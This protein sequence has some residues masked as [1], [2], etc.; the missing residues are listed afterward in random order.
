VSTEPIRP[1]ELAKPV[2][3]HYFTR[4]WYIDRWLDKR[5]KEAGHKMLAME[6]GRVRMQGERTGQSTLY[7]ATHASVAEFYS[8][9][10][11]P[12]TEAVCRSF[13]PQA[14]LDKIT[15]VNANGVK[16]LQGKQAQDLR[17]DF[18][19]LDAAN[20]AEQGRRLLVACARIAAP[21]CIVLMDDTDHP[22]TFKGRAAI[23]Y[24]LQ[25]P[26]TFRVEQAIKR[27][28]TSQGMTAI[29]ILPW[30]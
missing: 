8:I 25:H 7:I 14:A 24:A 27:D 28:R 18:I 10:V 29:R 16:W 9:D 3:I 30:K 13:F 19:Y 12:K 2:N 22:A 20:K 4:P 17:A 23:P 15:F 26:E 11:N 5:A 21:G 1:S 6:V